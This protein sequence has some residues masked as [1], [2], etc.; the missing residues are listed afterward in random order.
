MHKTKMNVFDEQDD[1]TGNPS[2]DFRSNEDE[3]F[4]TACEM[5]HLDMVKFFVSRGADVN[6]KNNYGLKWA[7]YQG[8]LEVVDYLVSIGADI[9]ATDDNALI[10]ASQEGKIDVVKFLLKNGANVN[11]QCNEAI[12]LA[13]HYKHY[14]VAYHLILNGAPIDYA[15]DDT[16]KF[17]NFCEK[18]KAKLRHRAAKKIYY[19]IIPILYRPGSISAYNLG[20]RGYEASMRNELV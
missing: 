14:E 8:H 20:L 6:A 19:W 9:H 1:L 10:L 3:A 15:S 18:M 7:S 2:L 12:F 17:I 4:R 5:G 13:N 11:A 16:R